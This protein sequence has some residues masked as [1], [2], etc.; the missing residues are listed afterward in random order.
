MVLWSAAFLNKIKD[1]DT[2][3]FKRKSQA[4]SLNKLNIQL[5]RLFEPYISATQYVSLIRCNDS[6]SNLV[7]HPV[8][9]TV[10]GDYIY[11]MAKTTKNKSYSY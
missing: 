4:M 7:Q 10:K 6:L 8:V 1:Y 9:S 3:F 2:G 5:F 11:L